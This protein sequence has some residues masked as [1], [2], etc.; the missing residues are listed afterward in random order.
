MRAQPI[1][2]IGPLKLPGRGNRAGG[3]YGV[4]HKAD[5]IFDGKVYASK[6]EKERAEEWAILLRNRLVLDVIEQPR[7]WL[8]V[9]ENVYVP[10]FL[11][12]PIRTDK[13][14]WYEDVKGMETAA[15]KKNVKLWAR[16][17]RLPLHILTREGSSWKTEIITPILPEPP[18][19]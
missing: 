9:R 4:S 2:P 6:H 15:F 7:L 3:K 1:Q 18:H 12:I 17:G 5:R 13:D 8:G 10:D 11:V 16:Y 14:P 19:A